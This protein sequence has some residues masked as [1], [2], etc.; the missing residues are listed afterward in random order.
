MKVKITRLSDNVNLPQYQT[1]DSAAFD[2]ASASDIVVESGATELIPTGLVIQVPSQNVLLIT[3]RSSLLSKKGLI[4][5][6]SPGIVDPDYCGP[7]DEVFIQVYNMRDENVSVSAGER[8]AQGMIVPAPRVEWIETAPKEENRG[9]FGSTKGY[10]T[11]LGERVLLRDAVGSETQ[12]VL[13]KT[14]R[15]KGLEALKEE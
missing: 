13:R 9:G 3:P 1:Q 2:L 5:P 8:I 6:N 14:L 12:K 15:E 10:K 4:I 11:E 7:E